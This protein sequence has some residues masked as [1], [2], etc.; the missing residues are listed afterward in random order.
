MFSKRLTIRSEVD[1]RLYGT[2][3]YGHAL[4]PL[5]S[6]QAT[7]RVSGANSKLLFQFNYLRPFE[8]QVVQSAMKVSSCGKRRSDCLLSC[9]LRLHN[10]EAVSRKPFSWDKVSYSLILVKSFC[11]D[12]INRVRHTA[13][14]AL[15]P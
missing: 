2:I 10:V 5:R 1:C 7:L 12:A 6:S 8:K 13:Q 14:K 9:S 3:D 4:L 11:Q 15:L